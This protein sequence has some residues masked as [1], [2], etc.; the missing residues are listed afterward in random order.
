MD[1]CW[2][3]LSASWDSPG[4]TRGSALN[5]HCWAA[6]GRQAPALG[7][8]SLPGSAVAPKERAG[9]WRSG[10][11][12][13]TPQ[14]FHGWVCFVGGLRVLPLAALRAFWPE[15]RRRKA[16]SPSAAA[17]AFGTGSK[18][19]ESSSKRNLKLASADL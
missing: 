18:G 1:L 5:S 14:L 2:E 10:S 19:R 12:P 15:G 16:W 3:S 17:I 9:V 4:L 13:C 6:S 8:S 7:L 11:R